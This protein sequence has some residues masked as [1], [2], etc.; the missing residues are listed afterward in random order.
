MSDTKELFDA[1]PVEETTT[2]AIVADNREDA[3]L[4]QVL[5]SGNIEILERYIALRKSEEER[6]SRIAFEEAFSKMRSELPAVAKKKDNGA[7]KSKYAPIEDIQRACDPVIHSF[8]FSYSWREEAIPEGKRVWMD[9][10]GYGHTRSNFF[11]CP[12]ISGNNAQNAIQ[13]AGAM[14]T[15]G[16]RYTFVSGFGVIVEGE[17]SDGQISDD[18]DVLK[19][20]LGDMLEAKDQA[21]KLIINQQAFDKIKEEMNKPDSDVKRLK[22]FYKWAAKKVGAV[23]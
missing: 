21:G 23:K 19:M 2:T 6:Q 5:T 3:L 10:S 16:R 7:T 11:D 20:R 8:G 15:Y 22:E 17:D 18:V 4:A 9:I 1:T 14:S 13:V 12:K